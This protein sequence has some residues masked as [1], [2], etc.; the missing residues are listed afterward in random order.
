MVKQFASRSFLL[1]GTRVTRAFMLNF[2]YYKFWLANTTKIQVFAAESIDS[3]Q[4]DFVVRSVCGI[5][6][7]E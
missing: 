3:A 7:I 5:F 1:R 6:W 4:T 2:D